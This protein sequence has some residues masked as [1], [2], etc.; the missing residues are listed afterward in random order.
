MAW[1]IWSL[2][3]AVYWFNI[4]GTLIVKLS[5]KK[6]IM[7][8]NFQNV[9]QASWHSFKVTHIQNKCQQWNLLN[10]IRFYKKLDIKQYYKAEIDRTR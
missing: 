8:L 6:V 5:T 4:N 2:I 1:F 3:T 9:L 10:K 7:V